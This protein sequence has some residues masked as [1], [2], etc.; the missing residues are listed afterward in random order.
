MPRT[1]AS[2]LSS[3]MPDLRTSPVTK[4]R[5]SSTLSVASDIGAIEIGCRSVIGRNGLPQPRAAN[6][7]AIAI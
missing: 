1:T 4:T 5:P 2:A 6:A 3:P 7:K